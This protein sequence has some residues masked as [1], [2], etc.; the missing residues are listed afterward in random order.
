MGRYHAVKAMLDFHGVPYEVVVRL[1][2]YHPT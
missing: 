2:I 1:V